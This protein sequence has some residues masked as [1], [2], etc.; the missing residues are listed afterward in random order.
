[1]LN[2]SLKWARMYVKLS[3]C[4]SVSVSK[5]KLVEVRFHI[6]GEVICP[7][8]EKPVEFRQVVQFHIQ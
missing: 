8:V 4:I 5:G 3:K 1:M 2:D 7:I 6:D